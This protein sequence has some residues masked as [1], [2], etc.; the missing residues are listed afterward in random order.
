MDL[1]LH[2]EENE[3]VVVDFAAPAWCV[4]CQRLAPHYEAVSEKMDGVKF[5]SVDID[6]ADPDLVESYQ[7]KGV[8][9]VLAFK[10]GEL[11]GTVEARTAPKLV[12][13]ISSL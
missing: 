7:I 13:E 5:L 4:P 3:T 9:T 11:A 12:S 6:T 2:L 10:D 1:N 8:P